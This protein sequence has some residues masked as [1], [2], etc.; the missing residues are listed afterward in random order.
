[1]KRWSDG[2]TDR[3]RAEGRD[4]RAFVASCLRRSVALPIFC[5]LLSACGYQ[6]SN[7]PD[8]PQTSGYKWQSLYRQDVQTVA[9][10]IFTNKSFYRGLEFS[11]TKAVIQQIEL[12]AGYKVVSRQRADTIL[13]GEIINVTTST[14]SDSPTTTLPQ[15]QLVTLTVN[16]TWKDLRTGKILATRHN[17]QQAAAF[18]PT[19]G[20]GNFV[21]SQQAVEKLAADITTELQADW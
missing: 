12:R 3:R 5:L 18:Y 13:E 9:V 21:G 7:N 2:A 14:L 19:L 16:F 11:L 4:R 1:M 20:E 17:F 6:Q 8:S 10:P 15:E